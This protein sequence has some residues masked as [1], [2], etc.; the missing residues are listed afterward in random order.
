MKLIEFACTGLNQF[1]QQLICKFRSIGRC[2]PTD[3]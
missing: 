3:V 1:Y 2:K